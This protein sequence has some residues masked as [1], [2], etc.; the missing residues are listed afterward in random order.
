MR[1]KI[2][3]YA[4]Y[5]KIRRQ[6]PP[7]LLINRVTFLSKSDTPKLTTAPMVAN[8]TVLATSSKFILARMLNRVPP[9]VPNTVPLCPL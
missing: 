9:M 6:A 4:K 1:R 3:E 2:E 5:K 7:Y 8:K